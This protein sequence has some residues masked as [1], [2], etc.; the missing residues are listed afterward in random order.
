M[1]LYALIG[2]IVI[3]Y[4]SFSMGSKET[5]KRLTKKYVLIGRLVILIISKNLKFVQS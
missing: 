2:T 1:F 3:L 4:D 5:L